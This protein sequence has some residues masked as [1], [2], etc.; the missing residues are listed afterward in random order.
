MELLDQAEHAL[1]VYLDRSRQ[2]CARLERGDMD[3]VM[4][5]LRRKVAAFH[6]FR[7]LDAMLI[8][9]GLELSTRESGREMWTELQQVDRD[10]NLRLE[11]L[12]SELS[13]E[14]MRSRRARVG[15]SKY[16]SGKQL[17]SAIQQGI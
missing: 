17:R 8:S 14:L 6:N 15:I 10:L 16:H 5:Q 2:V 1:R 3:G 7:A 4:L 9:R 12:K 13:E 11:G